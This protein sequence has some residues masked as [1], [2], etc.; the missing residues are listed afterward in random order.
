M[1]GCARAG[2]GHQLWRLGAHAKR[3]LWEDHQAV[4][5]KGGH[6][7]PSHCPWGVDRVPGTPGLALWGRAGRGQ[8][9]P[10]SGSE[11]PSRRPTGLPQLPAEGMREAAMALRVGRRQGMAQPWGWPGEGGEARLL[12]KPGPGGG[13]KGGPV[14]PQPRCPGRPAHFQQCSRELWGWSL[15]FWGQSSLA[16]ARRK[17]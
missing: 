13:G 17:L 4:T 1:R 10:G 2:P 15:S 6:H 7:W 11:G 8:P 3:L 12:G 5:A 9:H 14:P 16:K